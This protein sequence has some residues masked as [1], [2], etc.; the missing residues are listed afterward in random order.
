MKLSDLLLCIEERTVVW[1]GTSENDADGIYFG[2]VEGVTCELLR[3]YAARTFYP[4]RYPSIPCIG[5]TI[6]VDPI[7]NKPKASHP[8][9]CERCH[10]EYEKTHGNQRF[11]PECN[12]N[13][14]RVAEYKM[15]KKQKKEGS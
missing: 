13:K 3:K 8:A 4:E 10:K 1:I 11:C 12:K 9:E 15:R 7:G 5:I 2:E 14:V 6:L